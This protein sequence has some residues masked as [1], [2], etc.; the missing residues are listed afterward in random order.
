LLAFQSIKKRNIIIILI[1][2]EATIGCRGTL[3]GAQLWKGGEEGREAATNTPF[4]RCMKAGAVVTA[5]SSIFEA[6]RI[7]ATTN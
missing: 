6:W 5:I 3:G 1:H 2:E 7:I 4:R